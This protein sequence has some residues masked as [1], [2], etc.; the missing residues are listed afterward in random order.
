MALTYTHHHYPEDIRWLGPT[1]NYNNEIAECYHCDLIKKAHDHTNN[2]DYMKQMCTWLTCQDKI[3]WHAQYF[4]W[5][6]KDWT[7]NHIEPGE[8][9]VLKL[10]GEEQEQEEQEEENEAE[11]EHYVSEEPVD[12]VYTQHQEAYPGVQGVI[13][14]IHQRVSDP[15][16]S[17]FLAKGLPISGNLF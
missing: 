8:S 17:H 15:S 5:L 16:V 7:N 12:E 2:K 9:H 4:H 10:E 1:N 14:V 6:D 11:A 3:R 13:S